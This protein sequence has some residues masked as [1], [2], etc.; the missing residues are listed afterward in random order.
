MV[1]KSAS[2]SAGPSQMGFFHPSAPP[3]SMR[4]TK[5]C[6]VWGGGAL[7]RAGGVGGARPVDRDGLAGV[8]AAVAVG[9]GL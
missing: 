7:G 2:L 4:A 8:V 1:W 5:A 3:A 6:M 9:D